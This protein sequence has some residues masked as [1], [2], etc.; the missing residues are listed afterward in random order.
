MVLETTQLLGLGLKLQN[1]IAAVADPVEQALRGHKRKLLYYNE[2]NHS[3]HS[4]L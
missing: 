1:K 3:G 2:K 4:F